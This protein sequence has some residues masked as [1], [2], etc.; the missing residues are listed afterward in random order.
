ML[1]KLADISEK[2]IMSVDYPLKNGAIG[3]TAQANP[4]RT[5]YRP[6][7]KILRLLQTDLIRH[8]LCLRPMPRTG[9]CLNFHGDLPYSASLPP[10]IIGPFRDLPFT[11]TGDC[12]ANVLP[13]LPSS[14]K[15]L[16]RLHDAVAASACAAAIRH[17]VFPVHEPCSPD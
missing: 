15:P 2:K 17:P 4:R 11:I 6:S 12:Y 1:S 10:P 5:V 8:Q 7:G 13:P 9:K 3:S 14:L 16:R